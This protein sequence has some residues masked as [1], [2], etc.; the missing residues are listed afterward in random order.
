MK[1]AE[2]L[3]LMESVQDELE[4]VTYQ[5]FA[6][7]SDMEMAIECSLVKVNASR[8]FEVA[9]REASQIFGGSAIV[10][11]GQ[12]KIVERMYRQVRTTNIP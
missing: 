3:R 10:C 1:L 2:M 5:F 6:G 7:T 9:A 4:R 11:E 12:G 8:A